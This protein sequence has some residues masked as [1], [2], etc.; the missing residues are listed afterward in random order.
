MMMIMP[1]TIVIFTDLDGTLLDPISYSWK[2]ARSALTVIKKK[3]IPLVICSSKTRAEIEMIRRSLDNHDPLICENGGGIFI[4][5]NYFGFSFPSHKET[6]HYKIIELGAPYAQL[7]KVLRTVAQQT[8][9]ELKGFGDITADEIAAQTGLP[10][11]EAQLAKQR[12][13]DEPFILTG[14]EEQK[15]HILQLITRLGL[16]W[17]RGSRYYHLTGTHDKGKAVKFLA[18]LYKQKDGKV[19]TI[20]LGDSLNDLPMLQVVDYPILVQKPGGQYEESV[21]LSGLI[22]AQGIGPEGWRTA[23][24][25]L[26]ASVGN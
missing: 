23:V 2:A 12:E 22:K 9:V 25:K 17:T 20:G 5:K 14:N 7:R 16:H 15:K 4:P 13:Y 19:M 11:E 21:R 26:L 24:L 3:A 1:N 10:I 6:T 8:G 18:D